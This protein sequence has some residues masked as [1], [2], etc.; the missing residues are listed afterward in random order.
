[1][2]ALP[3]LRPSLSLLALCLP[4]ALRAP[5]QQ[6]ASGSASAVLH[7]NGLLSSGGSAQSS[8]YRLESALGGAPVESAS[9]SSAHGLQAGALVG[10]LGFAPLL[11]LVFAISASSGAALGGETREAV[12]FGF[13][14]PGA[15]T[16]AFRFA[17]QR[18]STL[19]VLDNARASVLTPAGVGSFGNPLGA[20]AVEVATAQGASSAAGAFVYAPALVQPLAAQLGGHARIE[21]VLPPA[22][23]YVLAVGGSIPGFAL[24][25]PPLAGALEVI[26][27]LLIVVG[28]Q[29]TGSGQA[30]FVVPVPAQPQL[31]G[32]VFQFQ[33]LS[34]VSIDPLGGAFTNRLDLL[35]Q[36]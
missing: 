26:D 22:S 12:G 31:A 36:P 35:I 14:A 4:L 7:S 1:M 20:V 13:L 30:A 24:P 33:A 8:S 16:P 9:A 15:G 21:F 18:A 32:L 6:P 27:P 2:S 17:G 23:F 34:L 28:F 29:F 5:A 11:P 3:R 10:P 19:A 25:L